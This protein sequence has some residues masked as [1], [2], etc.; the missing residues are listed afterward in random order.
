MGRRPPAQTYR[1]AIG[2]GGS[3][4]K[5][6]EGDGL[7][8]EG[9]YVIDA[10]NAASGYHR[11]LHISYPSAADRADAARRGVAPGGDVMIHG[12]KNGFGWIGRLHRMA[13]WT[14]GCIALTD[15]EVD[16][17]WRA[18]PDGTPIEIRS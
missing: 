5:R 12:L 16:E 6:R 8:P 14:A 2:R 4:P 1:V 18:I 7:T 9:D 3:G 13:D 17:L 11:A 10:R 15:E